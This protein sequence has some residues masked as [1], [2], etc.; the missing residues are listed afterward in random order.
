[1][2]KTLVIQLVRTL[3]PIVRSRKNNVNQSTI[4]KKDLQVGNSSEVQTWRSKALKRS[5]YINHLNNFDEFIRRFQSIK[6]SFA[7]KNAY[8]IPYNLFIY[9]IYGID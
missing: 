6:R 5:V 7:L 2:H 4:V 1:M 3:F 8:F 9:N